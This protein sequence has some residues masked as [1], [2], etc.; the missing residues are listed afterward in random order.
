M[1]RYYRPVWTCGRYDKT[2]HSAIVYDLIGGMSHFF[3]DYS[4]DVIGQ[5]L[6][7]KR[8]KE[9]SLVNVSEATMI[10]TESLE[11]FFAQLECVGLLSYMPTTSD[12]VAERRRLTRD[13]F[14]QNPDAGRADISI[15]KATNAEMSYA[16]RCKFRITVVMLELTYRCSEACIHCYNPG[17]TRNDNEVSTRGRFDELTIADYRRIIDELYD[18]GVTKICLS[19]GDPFSKATVWDIIQYLYDKDIAIEIYTNGQNLLGKEQQLAD[20]FPCDVGISIY[21]SE[22]AVHDR[23][24]RVHGALDKSL[25]VIERL[26]DLAVPICIKC[27]IM[28]TNV[29][30]YRGVAEI[31]SRYGATLQIE[32]GIFDSADGDTCVS[33]YLRLTENEMRL[34]LRD[35]DNPLYVGKEVPAYGAV[36]KNMNDIGCRAGIQNFCITPTGNLIPCCSFHAVIGNLKERHLADILTDNAALNKITSLPLREYEEC[37]THDYCD[38]CKLCPGLNFAE[39]GSLKKAAE[40]NCY[41]AKV[42]YRL[43]KQLM[44]GHDP[45]DG[46]PLEAALKALPEAAPVALKKIQYDNNFDKEIEL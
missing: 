24:T 20:F 32:S 28:R 33:H 23:I 25:R 29:R 21:S 10:D 46:R 9:V 45:L 2:S 34:V 8:G 12:V 4:A 14:R 39:H 27:C 15:G 18:E 30:T 42:R 38:F 1:K 13:F 17:A 31:A 43:A 44:E 26:T 22:A 11:S 6:T 37:G 3:E 19:G 5:I 36:K 41:V 40:N 16:D 35:R 7:T